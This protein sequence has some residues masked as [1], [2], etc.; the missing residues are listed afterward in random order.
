MPVKDSRVAFLRLHVLGIILFWLGLLPFSAL[1]GEVEV[2]GA[3]AS[4][5]A[6]LCTVSATLEHA[7]SGWD[8]YANYWRILSP[9]GEEVG[10]RVLLHPHENEQPFT[11]SLGNIKVPSNVEY[12]TIEGHDSV[13]G[14]GGPTFKIILK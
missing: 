2:V 4:C 9:D 6:N 10:K 13:H 5:V 7:D 1:G 8:H 12:I 11:R 3:K 14:Y